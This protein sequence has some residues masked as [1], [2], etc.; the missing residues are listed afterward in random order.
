MANIVTVQVR[1]FIPEADIDATEVM[2]RLTLSYG[3]SYCIVEYTK[4]GNLNG[5][6]VLDLQ[7]GTRWSLG[8]ECKEVWRWISPIAKSMWI[9]W[10]SDDGSFVSDKLKVFGYPVTNEHCIYRFDKV[11]LLFRDPLEV[12]RL[13]SSSNSR[14]EDQELRAHWKV[15]SGGFRRSIAGDYLCPN[16]RYLFQEE[17]TVAS[18]TTQISSSLI[19]LLVF[20]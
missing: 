2:K 12:E 16:D 11:E 7:Y 10:S 13:S 17:P 8:N 6:R 9:R 18:P 1:I 20:L 15:F 19:D 5:C 3:S 14:S 4:W